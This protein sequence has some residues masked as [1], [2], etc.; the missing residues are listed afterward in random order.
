VGITPD[1][2][3]K[4]RLRRRGLYLLPNL[5]TTAAM[6]AGFFGIISAM[7]ERYEAA[8]ICIF[9]AMI[10]DG[11][12]GR[13]ARLTN[14]QSDFGAQYDSLSDVISFGVAPALIAYQWSLVALGKLGWLVAFIYTSA[15]ALR[16]ARFNTQADTM[17]KQYFQGLASPSAAAL[18]A[19]FVW[20]VND[21]GFADGKALAAGTL[22][23][24][25]LGALLMVSQF[26]YYSF[27][28]LDFRGPQP[29]VAGL[30][31]VMI[32][33]LISLNP[34]LM[35]FLMFMVYALSGPVLTLVYLHRHRASRRSIHD[36]AKHDD[37]AK[38]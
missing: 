10:L 15:A 12:D 7:G 16:L 36:A 2:N 9:V 5:L 4:P 18:V 11:L 37:D 1:N 34:S 13:V 29:F 28:T 35:L 31:V 8:A 17:D 6:F 23:V 20:L 3:L 38:Q 32:F 25:L 14:T 21:A 27:K 22:T 19:G 30:L 26:R 24:T 33:V